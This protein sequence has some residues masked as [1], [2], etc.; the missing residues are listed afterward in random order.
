VL[1]DGEEF[2]EA[3]RHFGQLVILHDGGVTSIASRMRKASHATAADP[4]RFSSGVIANPQ[5]GLDEGARSKFAT[6][7]SQRMK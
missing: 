5:Y 4:R 1:D 2:R 6:S 3:S 7:V